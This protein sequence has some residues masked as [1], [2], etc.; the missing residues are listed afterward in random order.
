MS[1]IGSNSTKSF[2]VVAELLHDQRDC[3]VVRRRAP[4]EEK[5]SA[6]PAAT[7]A[8]QVHQL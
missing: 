4:E 7:S 8:F 5:P 3:D 1:L 6:T 2:G